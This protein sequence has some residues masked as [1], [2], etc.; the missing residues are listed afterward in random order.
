VKS[1]VFLNYAAF[2]ALLN[3]NRGRFA[4]CS[5]KDDNLLLGW[6]QQIIPGLVY[7]LF[8]DKQVSLDNFFFH[9]A[10]WL[11]WK[12]IWNG[13]LW[14]QWSCF[15]QFHFTSWEVLFAVSQK[16]GGFAFA[17]VSANPSLGFWINC[18]QNIYTM[19]STR[20]NVTHSKFW[21]FYD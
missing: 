20:R 14:V 21:T 10:Y 11:R 12:I 13:L 5:W 16:D 19:E 6:F 9:N 2:Q 7:K 18:T 3:H 4:W 15:K 1:H 8:L 17:L